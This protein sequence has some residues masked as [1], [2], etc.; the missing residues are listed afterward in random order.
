MTGTASKSG[1]V[2]AV[3]VKSRIAG[4]VLTSQL[5]IDVALMIVASLAIGEV[6]ASWLLARGEVE[7]SLV[8]KN[9]GRK[10]K[11]S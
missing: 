4:E 9:G 2:D 5:L 11:K 7:A 3:D 6:V 8:F 1:D 10:E